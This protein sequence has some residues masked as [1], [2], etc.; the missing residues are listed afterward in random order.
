MPT[1]KPHRPSL[2]P[3]QQRLVEENIYRARTM[4]RAIRKPICIDWDDWYGEAYLSLVEAV[5]IHQ[6]EKGELFTIANTILKRRR[7]RLMVYGSKRWAKTGRFGFPPGME[8]L[9]IDPFADR[10][11]H[12]KEIAQVVLNS[13]PGRQREAVTL[14]SRGMTYGNIGK[15]VGV[16][17]S[18]AWRIVTRAQRI[19]RDR[20]PDLVAA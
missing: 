3:A 2:N 1:P 14:R 8:N 18:Q 11:D 16:S 13:L 19:A 9:A 15:T 10:E 17:E 12:S 20:F 7:T 6:P 5:Q 4:A